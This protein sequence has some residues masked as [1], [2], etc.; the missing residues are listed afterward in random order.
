MTVLQ[1]IG[2]ALLALGLADA[3]LLWLILLERGKPGR[4][5]H[6]KG[7]EIDMPVSQAYQDAIAKLGP[8]IQTY[9]AAMQAQ[10]VKRG[11]AQ[12]AA[13]SGETEAELEQDQSDTIAA[14]NDA[15]AA[16]TALP[17]DPSAAPGQ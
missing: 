3:A 13:A 7:G 11:L 10:G 8:A 2:L 5:R 16:A 4:L 15:V 17:A 12:A 1:G 9:G 14:I 6:P